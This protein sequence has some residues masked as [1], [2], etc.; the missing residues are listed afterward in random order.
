MKYHEINPQMTFWMIKRKLT[1][2][3][4]R[5]LQAAGINITG[6]WEVQIGNPSNV[7]KRALESWRQS[8]SHERQRCRNKEGKG[9][10]RLSSGCISFFI[11]LLPVC[12]SSNGFGQRR[13]KLKRGFQLS[14][15]PFLPFRQGSKSD[16]AFFV[17]AWFSA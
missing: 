3:C 2:L 1:P 10:H 17:K 6:S 5:S 14:H 7:L 11:L 9:T 8:R 12:T 16:S 4:S 13:S 15:K